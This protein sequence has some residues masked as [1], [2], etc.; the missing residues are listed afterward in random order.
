MQYLHVQETSQGGD[1]A[2]PG[3]SHAQGTDKT[4]PMKLER[5]EVTHT[6][7]QMMVKEI[8]SR[9]MGCSEML[10]PVCMG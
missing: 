8:P 2:P 6:V 7:M 1:I 10:Q 9:D 4:L 3:A 5:L